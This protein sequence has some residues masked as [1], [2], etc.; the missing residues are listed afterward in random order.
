MEQARVLSP[1]LAGP[2]MVSSPV[3]SPM[4]PT[5]GLGY[6]QVCVSPQLAPLSPIA[7]VQLG[8]P[9]MSPTTRCLSPTYI[10]NMVFQEP[11]KTMIVRLDKYVPPATNPNETLEEKNFRHALPPRLLHKHKAWVE[12]QL[13]PLAE[14]V[15]NVPPGL[16]EL[17]RKRLIRGDSRYKGLSDMNI[18]AKI[19]GKFDPVYTNAIFDKLFVENKRT[20]K[21]SRRRCFEVINS[22][23][24]L[25]DT[26][27]AFVI[28]RPVDECIDVYGPA[29]VV[30]SAIQYLLSMQTQSGVS[31]RIIQVSTAA[32]NAIIK[33]RR[34]IL[35]REQ[36]SLFVE[37][38]P[39]GEEVNS[40]TVTIYA[41]VDMSHLD[42]A[43]NAIRDIEKEI[44][45]EEAISQEI[46]EHIDPNHSP[47]PPL[48]DDEE[49]RKKSLSLPSPKSLLHN[50][51]TTFTCT[52]QNSPKGR[53]AG[54]LRAIQQDVLSEPSDEYI[55]MIP[56]PLKSS[57]VIFPMSESSQ[58]LSSP[59]EDST[60]TMDSPPD[61]PILFSPNILPGARATKPP[62]VCKVK[63]GE[64]LN[65]NLPR[66]SLSENDI[67]SELQAI[68][69]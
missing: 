34:M 7:S 22:V 46:R 31:K 38:A 39:R 2:V 30:D 44:E 1:T 50:L 6:A 21:S 3:L 66:G 54:I 52:E 5:G 29:H 4:S 53:A 13:G 26:T 56:K 25:T 9:I 47:P 33:N 8:S 11:E 35:P 12:Q 45:V 58:G 49:E 36:G 41:Y 51:A 19:V 40:Q 60:I 68:L 42:I 43:E 32:A 67:E 55:P 10:S 15:I 27:G 64:I 37:P 17:S 69:S 62:V 28:S 65:V 61:T 63:Q 23:K 59:A 24:Q 18:E 57:E 20:V 16:V 14:L 48:L